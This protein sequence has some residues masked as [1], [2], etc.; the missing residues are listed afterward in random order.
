VLKLSPIF[1]D[2]KFKHV[3]CLQTDCSHLTIVKVA[4]IFP[5]LLFASQAEKKWEQF[6]LDPISKTPPPPF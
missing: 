5:A 4:I 3:K 2:N 6:S 1:F